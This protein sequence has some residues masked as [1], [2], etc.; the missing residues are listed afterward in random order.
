ML[1]P[2]DMYNC[3]RNR[4]LPHHTY[5][6]SHWQPVALSKPRRVT[7]DSQKIPRSTERTSPNAIPKPQFGCRLQCTCTRWQGTVVA[8][9][10]KPQLPKYATS[11]AAIVL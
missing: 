4:C 7:L 6:T 1:L 8:L 2:Y 10:S 11:I 9:G 3:T 5:H